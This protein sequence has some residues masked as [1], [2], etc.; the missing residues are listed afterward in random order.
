MP[1][2]SQMGTLQL[3]N[4]AGPG[5][6]MFG[7]ANAGYCRSISPARLDT[8]VDA[9]SPYLLAATVHVAIQIQFELG[10]LLVFLHRKSVTY[11]CI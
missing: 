4:S 6:S 2:I 7:N 9:I 3:R 10:T 5:G 8:D 11:L 1:L